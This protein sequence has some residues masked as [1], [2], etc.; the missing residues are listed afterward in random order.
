M[1]RPPHPDSRLRAQRA[2]VSAAG[3]L[4]PALRIVPFTGRDAELDELHSW[5]RE[6]ARV[7][8]RFVTGAGGVG[9]SRLALEFAARLRRRGW[10]C[11]WPEPDD[12]PAEVAAACRGGRVL[13]VVDDAAAHPRLAEQLGALAGAGESRLRVILLG[14]TG[15]EWWTRLR[16]ACDLWAGPEIVPTSQVHLAPPRVPAPAMVSTA[17]R[18]FAR[19]AGVRRKIAAAAPAVPEVREGPEPAPVLDVHAAALAALLRG[20]VADVSRG[21]GAL[22]DVERER[23]SAPDEEIAGAMLRGEEFGPASHAPGRSATRPRLM[24]GPGGLPNRLAELH[25]ARTLAADPARVRACTAGLDASQA[26][27][28]AVFAHRLDVD[29]PGVPEAARLATV[30]LERVADALPDDAE[31]LAHVLRLFGR[32]PLPRDVALGLAERLVAVVGEHRADGRPATPERADATATLARALGAPET[33]DEVPPSAQGAVT[34]WRELARQ[35]PGRYRSALL[36]ARTVMAAVLF[37]KGRYTESLQISDEV[38]A[39]CRAAPAEERVWTDPVLAT[40]LNGMA[41][42]YDFLGRPEQ[43][44]VCH[45]ASVATLR[46]LVA[47]DPAAHE[48]TLALVLAN[49]VGQVELGRAADVIDGLRESVEIRRRLTLRRPGEHEQ[50]LAFA[51]SNLSDAAAQLDRPAEAV[52]AAREALAIRRRF[53]EQDPVGMRWLVAWSLAGLGSLLSEQGRAAEAAGLEEEAVR[54]RRELA[55]ET[56]QRY[57][58]MLATSCSNLA[59]TYARLGRFAEAL[60]LEEEA[61]GIRRELAGRVP[62]R[63]EEDL[64]RSLSRLGVRL[65]EVARPLD[66]VAPATEAVSMLRDLARSKQPHH[67]DSLA[68][69]LTNLATVLRSLGRAEAATAAVQEA[70][71]LRDESVELVARERGRRASPDRAVD[72]LVDI[73]EGGAPTS[74]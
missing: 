51:L 55:Q 48:A 29:D 33:Y 45:T 25:V 21:V 63:Y 44:E 35:D 53:A 23:W 5:C 47:R 9:K 16:W 37:G 70:F 17:V 74:S 7:Q 66:A 67:Q 42:A 68:V 62:G 10:T 1:W 14:R 11:V 57:R 3:L 56:P 24:S 73:E 52:A 38:A 60:P 20:G 26:F 58:D 8:V 64:A 43:V 6:R 34:A 19:R 54:I 15:R 12:S 59:V 40:A 22:L 50:Y 18:A 69:A 13:V 28:L 49:T 31:A 32:R 36:G 71:A 46:R 4:D 27:H 65:T 2:K 72:V 30:L 41:V 61:V 39:A